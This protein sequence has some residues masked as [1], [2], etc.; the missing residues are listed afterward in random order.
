MEI[1][2]APSF[3]RSGSSCRDWRYI[4]Y[5]LPVERWKVHLSSFHSFVGLH[6]NCFIE[7]LPRANDGSAIFIISTP[8]IISLAWVV[9]SLV[10]VYYLLS[11]LKLIFFRASSIGRF[12]FIG[13]AIHSGWHPPSSSFEV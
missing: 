1:Y 6:P 3:P 9:L 12:F 8:S 7:V 5:L 11:V 4:V 10:L 13:R 2:S